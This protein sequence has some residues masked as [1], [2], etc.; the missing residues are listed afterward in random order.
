MSHMYTYVVNHIACTKQPTN[1]TKK[2]MGHLVSED[3]ERTKDKLINRVKIC[4]F[5]IAVF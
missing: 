2:G 1:K 4:G 3:L 5:N